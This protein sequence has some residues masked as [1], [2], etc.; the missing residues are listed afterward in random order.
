ML[1]NFCACNYL[2]SDGLVNGANGTFEDYINTFPILLL[3][4]FL[5]FKLYLIQE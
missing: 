5:M 3:W 2:R 1:I 4:I